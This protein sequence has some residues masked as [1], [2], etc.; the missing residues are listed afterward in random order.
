MSVASYDHGVALEVTDDVAIVVEH[1][2]GLFLE[3]NGPLY[4]SDAD[5][6]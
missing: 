6:D 5:H 4:E 2:R 3:V 1:M